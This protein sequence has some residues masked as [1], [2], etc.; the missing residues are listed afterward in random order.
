MH[1]DNVY[2]VCWHPA[3]WHILATGCWDGIL[4][5]FDVEKSSPILL[6]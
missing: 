5:I 6:K 4:R 1:P 2:G 3:K